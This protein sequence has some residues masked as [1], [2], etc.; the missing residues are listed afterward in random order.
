MSRSVIMPTSLSFSPTGRAP[1]SRS[2][3]ILAAVC[4]VSSGCT[5]STSGV[6]SSLTFITT[7]FGFGRPAGPA[8]R[9]L[10][11]EAPSFAV[12][13][14][15]LARTGGNALP[16]GVFRR[17][18]NASGAGKRPNGVNAVAQMR[19][20]KHGGNM[21]DED[22]LGAGLALMQQQR[23]AEA[24][25][26]LDRALRCCP[27][28]PALHYLRGEALFLLRRLDE[29]LDAHAA[30]CRLALREDADRGATMSGLVPG[31]FGWMSHMLRGDFARAWHL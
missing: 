25:A 9:C 4:S 13:A 8:D 24:I 14:S 6:I 23:F 19:L 18:G 2:A 15:P 17:H 21:Q 3:I 22:W 27:D 30:A 26:L 7:P 20:R 29:A 31:D 16:L 12:P 28:D 10:R 1:V 11:N 5:I